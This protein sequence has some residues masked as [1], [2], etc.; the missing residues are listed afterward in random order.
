MSTSPHGSYRKW[1][2]S[3][4][5][6]PQQKQERVSLVAVM[7]AFVIITALASFSLFFLFAVTLNIAGERDILTN[8]QLYGIALGFCLLRGF[9][10]LM[11]RR[12][13]N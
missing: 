12:D 5:G 6:K 1:L 10:H 13:K 9:D 2:R 3:S 7:I 8:R 4:D 11:Y